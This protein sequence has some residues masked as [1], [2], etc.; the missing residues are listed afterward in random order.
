MILRI[1]NDIKET[2]KDNVENRTE[3]SGKATRK[4]LKNNVNSSFLSPE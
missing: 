4:N 1:L 3:N 2:H